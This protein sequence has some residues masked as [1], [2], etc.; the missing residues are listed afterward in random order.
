MPVTAR[1]D[2]N[3]IRRG[4][5][6][7][8]Q[9]AQPKTQNAMVMVSHVRFDRVRIAQGGDVAASMTHGTTRPTVNRAK[10]TQASTMPAA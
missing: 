1:F 3:G 5:P 8:S 10:S 2:R 9:A 6:A 7:I 4:R